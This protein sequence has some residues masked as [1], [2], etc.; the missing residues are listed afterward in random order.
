MLRIAL[1]TTASLLAAP[2]FAGGAVVPVA[3][4]VVIAAAPI[5]DW[6]GGYVGLQFGT[7][8]DSTITLAGTPN[9]LEADVYGVFGGYRFDL[10]TFVVGGEL[11]YMVGEGDLTSPGAFSFDIDQLVRLG[12]EG[13]YDLGNA[14]AYAT[15]G[16][17]Q[18]EITDQFGTSDDSSGY[19]YGIGADIRVTDRVT[20]GAELLQ[21]E[22]EDFGFPNELEILTFGLNVAFTF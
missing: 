8:L 9:D 14:L 22:F 1:A 5:S 11:D 13:G 12:I 15:V 17:A 7:T 3:P 2:A 21:H 19:F 20:I 6:T 18:I 4:P 16:L 10:G